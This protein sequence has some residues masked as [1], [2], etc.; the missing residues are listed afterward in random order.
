MFKMV[1]MKK[2]DTRNLLADIQLFEGLTPAQLDW[3]SAICV[4]FR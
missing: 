1:E 3:G 2:D 4:S